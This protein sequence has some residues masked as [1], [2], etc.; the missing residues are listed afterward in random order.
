MD[1][2]VKFSLFIKCSLKVNTIFFWNFL[3][4]H[5]ILFALFPSN[6]LYNISLAGESLTHVKFFGSDNTMWWFATPLEMISFLCISYCGWEK[7]WM[8]ADCNVLT[9]GNQL[10]LFPPLWNRSLHNNSLPFTCSLKSWM[11]FILARMLFTRL[12]WSC[13]KLIIETGIFIYLLT[14]RVSSI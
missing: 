6:S 11:A 7:R 14:P 3:E 5:F 9:S 10:F 4:V 12:L 2:H 1:R 13:W 8:R